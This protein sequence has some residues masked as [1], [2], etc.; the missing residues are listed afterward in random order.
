[1][2]SMQLDI[3]AA[4]PLEAKRSLVDA[5]SEEYS[6][7]M[8][9]DPRLMTIVI[10]ELPNGSIWHCGL[11]ESSPG[12]LLMCDIRSG[13]D[14]ATRHALAVRLIDIIATRTNVSAAH[15]K[16]EFTQ[17][18]GEEMFH[19]FLGGFNRDWDDLEAETRITDLRPPSLP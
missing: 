9:S 13:R 5:M 4:L 3:M 2:P 12:T 8:N 15:I 16:V 6:R 7:T 18:P 14:I 10:R 1:M 17:H 11:A 19:P